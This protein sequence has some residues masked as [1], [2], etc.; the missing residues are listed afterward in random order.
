[1]VTINALSLIFFFSNSRLKSEP[2]LILLLFQNPHK[3][4]VIHS[5]N[6]PY[7]IPRKRLLALLQKAP[8][9]IFNH[10][11]PQVLGQAGSLRRDSNTIAQWQAPIWTCCQGEKRKEPD[12]SF[13]VGRRACL[14]FCCS[15]WQWLL[16]DTARDHRTPMVS[17]SLRGTRG[18]RQVP[19]R[20]AGRPSAPTVLSSHMCAQ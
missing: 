20:P 8:Q 4:I 3:E 1:M 17:V 9:L 18:G 6:F 12:H 5:H 7:Q 15:K 14:R 16:T 2:N 10:A 19:L 11:A 13:Q